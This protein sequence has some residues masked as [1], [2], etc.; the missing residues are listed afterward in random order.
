MKGY[1]GKILH[2]DLTRHKFRIEEPD[3]AFYRLYM[4]GSCLGSYY[5]MKYMPAGAD[6]FDPNNVLVFAVSATTGAPISGASRF[7]VTAKSPLTG[8]I[9]DSQAGGF[10]GAELKYAGFDAIVMTGR[11][12]KPVYLWIRDGEFGLKDGFRV[13]GKITG[14]AQAIIREELGDPKV[15]IAQIG[16]AGENLVRYACITNELKHYNGRT[17]M[18]AVMGSKNLKAIAVRGTNPPEFSERDRI[19]SMARSGAK[20]SHKHPGVQGLREYGTAAVISANQAMGGLPTRNWRSGVFEHAENISGATMKNTILQKNE[21]CW[22]CVVRCKRVVAAEEPYEVDPAYGGPEYE[23]IAALGSYLGIGN[24]V[25]V[26]KAA[27]LC[28]KYGLDTISTGGTLAFAMECFE[29]GIITL[30]DT[31]GIELN[32]GNAD[33]ALKTITC[34]AQRK[35]IGDI[36]AAGSQKA[37]ERFG[38]GAE[39]YAI[40][41]KGQEFPAHMPRVKGSLSLAYACNPFGADHQSSQHDPAISAQPFG[42][43]MTALGFRVAASSDSL[44]FEKVRLWAYTQRLFSAL[45]TLELCQFCF[46]PGLLYGISDIVELVNAATG[47]STTLWEIMQV[48]ERRINLMRMF[49]AREGFSSEDDD[50]PDRVFEPLRGGHTEGNRIDREEFKE[51]KRQY[52]EMMGWCPQTGIPTGLKLKEL[53]LEWVLEASDKIQ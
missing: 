46:G 5:L 17:G 31:G 42:E 8:A 11:S 35:G 26:A 28:N 21:T 22:G 44:G 7:N 20:R 38:N 19:F 27:E 53:A 2:V 37:A 51:A 6:A 4:G 12:P 49:N 36:L 40:C 24:M 43:D 23:T 16:P 14:E 18:G 41:S 13:W 25:A 33:A 52:Y 1:C 50:L 10:W 29:N 32:F 47:W 45:D 39:K 15:R 9:G 30:E 34:I 48:G 3:E